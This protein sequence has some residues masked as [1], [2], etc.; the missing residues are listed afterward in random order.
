MFYAASAFK[1]LFYIGAIIGGI[2]AI[3]LYFLRMNPLSE[4]GKTL[5]WDYD[6][7][8][9]FELIIIITF[10]LCILLCLL[11]AINKDKLSIK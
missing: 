3:I 7:A 10:I 4:K 11:H 9:N 6:I 8:F 5:G 1:N 2:D